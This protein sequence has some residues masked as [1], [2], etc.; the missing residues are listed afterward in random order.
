MDDLPSHH[1]SPIHPSP[2]RWNGAS[3]VDFPGLLRVD[4]QNGSAVADA[5]A[6]AVKSFHRP[7]LPPPAATL[8]Q[9]S[10]ADTIS[11]LYC[12]STSPYHNPQ[13][14]LPCNFPAILLSYPSCHHHLLSPSPPFS[15]PRPLLC[16]H[17]SH[18]SAPLP[19]GS[20]TISPLAHRQSQRQH[21]DKG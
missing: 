1:S 13:F 12:A 19:A 2:I 16:H 4:H 8:R 17:Q 20:T 15:F 21:Q 18:G 3:A 14:H 11:C 9:V 6:I 7:L 10:S 5:V